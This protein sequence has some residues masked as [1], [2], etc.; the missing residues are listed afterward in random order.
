MSNLSEKIDQLIEPIAQDNSSGASE[1]ARRAA[2]V[3]LD[4]L[5]DL[6]EPS[7]A[8]INQLQPPMLQ[9]AKRLLHAQPKMATLFNLVNR[10]L[11]IL[12]ANRTFG[13]A[14]SAIEK[15]IYNFLAVVV[16]GADSIAQQVAPLITD[17]AVVLVHSYSATVNKALITAKRNGRRFDVF[18]TE[19]R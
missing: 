3:L 2:V 6:D 9:F 12:N 1:L 15:Y 11:L 19:S 4:L 17:D 5:A 16:G 8:P 13:E 14:K 10:T 18:C 7:S